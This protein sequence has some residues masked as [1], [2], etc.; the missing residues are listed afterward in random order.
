M[1]GRDVRFRVDAAAAFAFGPMLNELS[2]SNDAAGG[3]DIAKLWSAAVL[4][5]NADGLGYGDDEAIVQACVTFVR[6][7]GVSP[8]WLLGLPAATPWYERFSSFIQ[9][10]IGDTYAEVDVR[11]FL[12]ECRA[13]F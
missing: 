10:A 12:R 4:A 7:N 1:V 5:A 3:R 13:K 9:A 11:Y 6:S 2:G 8:E